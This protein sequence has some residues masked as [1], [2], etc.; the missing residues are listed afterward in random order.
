MKGTSIS[1]VICIL[2]SCMSC[3]QNKTL[4]ETSIAQN[5]EFKNVRFIPN[6]QFVEVLDSS[7]HYFNKEDF[8]I[9]MVGS[10]AKGDK[11]Y[12]S[13]KF[14]MRVMLRTYYLVD[15]EEYE[16]VLRTFSTDFKIID[17]YIM[18]STLNDV[19]CN[20]SINNNLEITTTCQDGVTTLT[21]VD[22][23]GKFI[24]Q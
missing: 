13:D 11:I 21:M 12:S 19:V 7:Y 14:D 8:K 16:F 3:Q 22:E 10:I 15:R 17:S 2:L 18:S 24:K 9:A 4:F 23:Y 6:M 20:G 5:A 1:I